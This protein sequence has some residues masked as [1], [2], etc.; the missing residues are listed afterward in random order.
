MQR[1]N[2]L[3]RSKCESLRREIKA[4]VRKRHDLYVNILVDDVKA[5]PEIVIGIS[6]VRKKKPI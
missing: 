5:K 6:M 3:N 4:A 2:R 1:Q